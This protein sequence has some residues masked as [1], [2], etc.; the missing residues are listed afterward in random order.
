MSISLLDMGFEE[1]IRVGSAKK[2]SKSILPYRYDSITYVVL[3]ECLN[4]M[5]L[6]MFWVVT[7]LDD[8]LW[9]I[10]MFLML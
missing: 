2:I 1:F 6:L 3:I 4:D 5:L 9:P 7:F 10:S 8:I